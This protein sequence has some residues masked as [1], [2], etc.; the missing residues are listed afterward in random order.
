MKSRG[1]TEIHDLSDTA[2][3]HEAVESGEVIGNVV[4][5]IK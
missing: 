2:R 4:V 1:L 5:Q 3:A